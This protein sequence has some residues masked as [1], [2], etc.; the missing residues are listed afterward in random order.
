M[1]EAM[2]LARHATA[3][4][5]L[6]VYAKTRQSRL[7][8]VAEAV[9]RVVNPGPDYAHSMH[10]QAVGAEGLDLN[11]LKA[12]TLGVERE[13]WRRRESNPRPVTAR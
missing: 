7:S 11:A 9:G 2:T 8:E 3:E 6:N 1:K 10:K 12:K 13:W 5:T 4:L